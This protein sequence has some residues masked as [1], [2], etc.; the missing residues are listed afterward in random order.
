MAK[1]ARAVV[2]AVSADIDDVDAVKG[3]L[4]DLAGRGLVREDYRVRSRL[5]PDLVIAYLGAHA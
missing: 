4:A 1:A 3:I 2:P 5:E